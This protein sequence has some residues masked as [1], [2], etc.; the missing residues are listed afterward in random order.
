MHCFSRI[1]H[2]VTRRPK[3][4]ACRSLGLIILV[5][6]LLAAGCETLQTGGL[7]HVLGTAAGNQGGLSTSTIVAGLKEALRVGTRK[8]VEQTSRDGG[9]SNSPTIR[10]PVPDRLETMASALRK[11]GLGGQVDAFEAKMNKAAER[12]AEEAAPV[13]IDAIQD[14][15]FAD[16]RDILQGDDTAATEYFRNK[17]HTELTR[18][19]APIVRQRMEQLGVVRVFEDLQNR[20]NQLPLVSDVNYR[21][22]DYV[23]AEALDG[24]F[25][26]LAGEEQKIR[27][28]PAARTTELLR[29]VFGE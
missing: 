16:A 20:Y 23:V 7:S 1:M 9:Y 27:E 28:N 18:R 22:E 21:I 25:T 3:T 15:T 14:M 24:L 26:V 5:C 13:F 17:T 12:A 11:V 19:Y 10:I 8:T 2:T 29:R 6:T 4:T